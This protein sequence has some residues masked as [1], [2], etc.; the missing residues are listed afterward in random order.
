MKHFI[1]ILILLFALHCSAQTVFMDE[2]NIIVT[3]KPFAHTGKQNIIIAPFVPDLFA[4]EKIYIDY[5]YWWTLKYFNRDLL[6][7][8][9]IN[10][11]IY[12][13]SKDFLTRNQ[14]FINM[15]ILVEKA[16]QRSQKDYP[17]KY[18]TWPKRE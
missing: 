14:A 7:L 3:E 10:N 15:Y 12:L 2:S 13:E 17:V 9:I 8:L 4:T 1:S 18:K 16:V 5:K 6:N 11:G